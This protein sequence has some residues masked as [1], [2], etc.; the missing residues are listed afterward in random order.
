MSDREKLDQAYRAEADRI[1]TKM[2]SDLHSARTNRTA[3]DALNDAVLLS[4][5]F[6]HDID[7]LKSDYEDAIYYAERKEYSELSAFAMN[8]LGVR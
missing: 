4:E 2:E 3:K 1:C 6:R 8:V 7:S 5:Q